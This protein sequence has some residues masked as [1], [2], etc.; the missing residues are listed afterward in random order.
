MLRLH[1]SLAPT[2]SYTG[3]SG[4][5]ASVIAPVP[6]H[7]FVVGGRAGYSIL[8]S[9]SAH[10]LLVREVVGHSMTRIDSQ[11]LQTTD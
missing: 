2:I 11:T 9:F 6:W 5:K 3:W 8:M 10:H 4:I 1:S 7:A